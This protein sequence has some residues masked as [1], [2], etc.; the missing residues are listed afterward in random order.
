M[1]EPNNS[2][3]YAGLPEL[4]EQL[5]LDFSEQ[6]VCKLCISDPADRNQL[7]VKYFQSADTLLNFAKSFK[8]LTM[9]YGSDL[10]SDTWTKSLICA[11]HNPQLPEFSIAH[12]YCHVWKPTLNHLVNLIDSVISLTIKLS[13]VDNFKDLPNLETQLMNLFHGVMECMKKKHDNLQPIRTALNSIKQYRLFC[14][15]CN[16]AD[17]F[18]ELRKVLNLQKGDFTLVQDFAADVRLIKLI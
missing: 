3:F 7:T 6:G 14:S 8:L 11:A 12:V 10:F 9:R 5:K 1:C 18:L 15:Y 16:G 2:L 13:D 17:V 4:L